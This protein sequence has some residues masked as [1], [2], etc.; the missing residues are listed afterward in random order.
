MDIN[1]INIQSKPIVVS[2]NQTA[3]NDRVYH[4][5]A[6]ATFTDPTPIEGRGYVV[7]VFNGIAN[8]GGVNYNGQQ[9]VVRRYYRAGNWILTSTNAS[10]SIN[11]LDEVVSNKATTMTGNTSSNTLYLTAKAIFDYVTA[12]FVRYAEYA[13]HSILAQQS[14]TG[15]PSS[16]PIGNNQILGR[17]SGGGSNI[18]G[19]SVS[20]VKGLLD[21]EGANTG[22]ETQSSILTKIGAGDWVDY[23]DDSTIVGWSSLT[24]KIVL[25]KYLSSDLMVIFA[26]ITGTSDST[27]ASFTL[28]IENNNGFGMQFQLNVINNGGANVGRCSVSPDSDVV[29]VRSNVTASTFTASGTKGVLGQFMLRIKP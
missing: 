3:E 14:G 11:T 10:S 21:L 27:T 8:I 9:Q 15:S 12:T 16:V 17:L 25:Y 13:S 1:L 22:D 26:Q 24:T 29:D 18:K 28:P 6:N 20:E 19:L 23:S 7:V 2:A 5:V 4:V